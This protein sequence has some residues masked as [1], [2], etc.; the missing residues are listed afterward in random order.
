LQCLTPSQIKATM[1]NTRNP[2]VLCIDDDEDDQYFIREALTT[3]DPAIELRSA[4]NG[5][6]GIRFLQQAKNDG[7]LPC[8]IILDMNMPALDGRE[9]FDQI[10]KDSELSSIP[11][12]VFTTSNSKQDRAYWTSKG[13]EMF[14]KPVDHKLFVTHVSGFIKHCG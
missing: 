8:L 7:A 14:T 13:I 9:T 4:D 2:L 6:K 5:V 12:V 10:K 3:L 1:N 11:I